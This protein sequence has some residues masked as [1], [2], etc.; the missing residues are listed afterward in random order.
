MCCVWVCCVVLCVCVVLCACAHVCWSVRAKLMHM[1]SEPRGA[2]EVSSSII[3]CLVPLRQGLSL[4]LELAVWLVNL[5][6]SAYLCPIALGLQAGMVMSLFYMGAWDSN[7]G[8][9]A[10]TAIAFTQSYPLRSLFSLSSE[11][12]Y[13]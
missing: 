7:L 1:H 4:T 11:L 5:L 13:I 3:L 12:E 2:C 6:G 8:H 9:H 10:C